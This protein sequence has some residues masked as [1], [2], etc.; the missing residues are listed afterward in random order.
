MFGPD[1]RFRDASPEEVSALTLEGMREAVMAQLHAGNLVR[2]VPMS[3]RPE[4]LWGGVGVMGWNGVWGVVAV[5]CGWVGGWGGETGT[6]HDSPPRNDA[7][8]DHW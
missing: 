3:A 1:R 4:P 5:V 8:L 2:G 6:G 7:P